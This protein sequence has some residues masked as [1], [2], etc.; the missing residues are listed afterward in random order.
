MSM[1]TLQKKIN[2]SG[3]VQSVSSKEIADRP[4]TNVNQAL[5]GLAANVNISQ[6]IGRSTGAPGINI[7][8]FTS[9]NGGGALILVDNAPLSAGELSRINPEDI[10]N[11][12]ILKDAAAAA[13]YGGRASF[14]VV[15]I[16]T[17]QARS[18]KMEISFSGN[19]GLRALVPPVTDMSFMPM[20]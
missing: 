11:I 5:Q 18:R 8:G 16:T 10:E 14:G 9:I 1:D 7:R 20:L 12:S 6:T 15:L 3:A 17:K 2:L 19:T 13:I 4:V